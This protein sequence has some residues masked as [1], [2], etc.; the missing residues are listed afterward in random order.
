MKE[1]LT[2]QE[3][4]KYL[5]EALQ[6]FKDGNMTVKEIQAITN[7]AGKIVQIALLDIMSK[8]TIGNN[9]KMLKEGFKE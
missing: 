5:W 6:D 7:T 8:N 1:K 2:S 3:L 9:G 4:Q